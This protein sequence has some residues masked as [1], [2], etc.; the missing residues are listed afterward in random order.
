MSDQQY[1]PHP[2]QPQG[3]QG[4][5]Q[6]GHY[7]PPPQGQYPPPGYPPQAPPQQWKVVKTGGTRHSM[8]ALISLFTCGA[9]LPVWFLVWLLTKK[10]KVA[11]PR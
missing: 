10:H 9:W 7:P 11:V 4:Y 8:H 6:Q 2:A 5:P 1:P 3:P